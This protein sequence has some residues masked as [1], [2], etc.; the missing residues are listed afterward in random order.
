MKKIIYPL[1]LPL[2]IA[3]GLAFANHEI[4]SETLKK[5][6]PKSRSAMDMKVE[7]KK[8]ETSPDGI[9]FKKWQASSQ[10]IKVLN[11]AAKI[12]NQVKDSINIEAVITSLY[13]PLG[14]QLGFGVMIR[15]K[16]EDYILSFGLENSNDFQQLHSLKV[17]DKI[18]IRSH[19]V[20]YAPKYSY[21]IVQG[22]YLERDGKIMYK[23]IP[24]QGGC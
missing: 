6:S 4:K 22:D 9:K 13:L 24:R 7:N 23:R 10:G 12:R 3:S 17:N 11:S 5:P 19:S 1:I 16:S 14:S 20:M 2:A 8:L 18:M 21:P 15:I